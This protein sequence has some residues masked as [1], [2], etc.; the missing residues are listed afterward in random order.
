MFCPKCG[1][2]NVDDGK[3]CRGCGADL[4]LMTGTGASRAAADFDLRSAL[5]GRV[6]D[7]KTKAVK[8]RLSLAE[9]SIAIKSRGIRGVLTG[10]GFLVIAAIL[11]SRPPENGIL[12]LIPLALA[13]IWFAA[14]I[15]RFVQASGYKKL[16]AKQDSPAELGAGREDYI[17]PPRSFY[18]TD[19]LAAAPFSVTERTTN[20][21]RK[22]GADEDEL[23]D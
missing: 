2:V 9:K 14:S 5:E 23:I 20:I 13:F 12:W 18:Q 17:Q 8:P 19:D 21:L 11:S 7:R 15:G 3:F 16:A 22:M 4:P 6:R 1:V 10:V